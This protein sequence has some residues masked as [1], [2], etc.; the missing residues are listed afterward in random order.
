M[1]KIIVLISIFIFSQNI[2]AQ[3][4]WQWLN[5]YPSN[6]SIYSVKMLNPNKIY[7]SG[8]FGTFMKSTNGG[9]NWTINAYINSMA[10]YF[11]VFKDITILNNY[12]YMLKINKFDYP[13]GNR[14]LLMKSTNDGTTWD[15]ILIS[16]SAPING[17]IQF[18]NSSTGYFYDSFGDTTKILKTTNSGI[19]WTTFKVTNDSLLRSVFFLNENTGWVAR[20]NTSSYYKTTDQG[21]TWN[22]FNISEIIFRPRNFFFINENTGWYTTP[23]VFFKTTNS[24]LNWQMK[25]SALPNVFPVYKFLNSEN[26][27]IMNA[28]MTVTTNGGSTWLDSSISGHLQTDIVEDGNGIS[29]DAGKIFKT[30]NYGVNWFSFGQ[31]TLLQ[32]NGIIDLFFV[33]SSQGYLTSDNFIAKTTNSGYT[34]YKTDTTDHYSNIKFFNENTGLAV[35]TYGLK[36]TTNAGENWFYVTPFSNHNFLSFSI[37]NS[38]TAFINDSLIYK[39][40]DYGNTWTYVSKPPQLH[41]ECF[42]L[43]ENN[44]YAVSYSDSKFYKTTN[45][46]NNWQVLTE[47]TSILNSRSFNF[48]NERTGWYSY[49]NFIR[50]TTN[51]GFNWVNQV[52]DNSKTFV[53]CKFINENTGWCV[54][55]SEDDGVIVKTTNGGLNWIDVKDIPVRQLYNIFMLNADIGWASGRNGQLIKT[56]SGGVPINI[57]KENNVIISN[58]VLSQNYPNPFNPST[59]INYEL[60]NT[61]YVTLKVFDLLGKEVATLVNEKQNAGSYAV[62]FNSAEFNLPSGIY[63]YTLN[64]GEFKETKKMVLVK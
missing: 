26:G 44:A 58:F 42:F 8:D 19:S 47:V 28:G 18:I 25:S 15:S 12:I 37:T 59:R 48:I 53:N 7:A 33:N 17:T 60:R 30:T 56:T 41:S 32:D 5:P 11:I 54:G 38:S 1:K 27:F 16:Q 2:F 49:S 29:F 64:S 40:T 35:V 39:T 55:Y 61:N 45:A 6:S 57:G 22:T 4:G 43:D 52:V 23:T 31:N 46:G 63:F 51:G 14:A 10:G 3:S 62:D 34:W 13:S 9:M 20:N 21:V 36:K 50:K 24:G